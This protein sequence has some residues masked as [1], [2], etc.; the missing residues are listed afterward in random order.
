VLIAKFHV[1]SV[2]QMYLL[3]V[4][5]EVTVMTSYIE[6]IQTK[7]ILKKIFAEFTPMQMKMKG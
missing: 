5:Y 7:I 6:S 3:L 2:F 1:M 4:W